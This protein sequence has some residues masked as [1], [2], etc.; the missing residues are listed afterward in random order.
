MTREEANIA[1]DWAI[2]EGVDMG[3]YDMDCFYQ[4]D[5]NG[6]FAGKLDNEIICVGSA[7]NYNDHFA[8]CGFYIT[9]KKFRSQGFGMK[10]TEERL[11]Y[12][13]D[14]IV[15]IDGV[16][17]MVKKY[18][19]ILGYIPWYQHIRYLLPHKITF[20]PPKDIIDLRTIPEQELFA[21]DQKYFPASRNEMLRCWVNQPDSLALGY[22]DNKLL[23]GYGVIRKSHKGRII[24][25]LFAT[26]Y[27][28]ADI[29]FQSLVSSGDS[30]CFL[31]APEINSK[32]LQ[33]AKKHQMTPIFKTVRMYRN[34]HPE[35]D[36][37]GIFG[38]TSLELG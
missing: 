27:D 19:R 33:L 4:A 21:F 1:V 37:N 10:L 22:R 6:F 25:P 12:T 14:R 7:V 34:G 32:A 23:Q 8:F 13:G 9:S 18:E 16:L 17:D 30:P 36:V 38:I 26:S 2:Q 31:V 20:K 5:P 24:A 29:L 3:F 28:I 15:G 35:I 11:S